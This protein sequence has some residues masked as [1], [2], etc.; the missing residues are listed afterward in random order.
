V[1]WVDSIHECDFPKQ[2]DFVVRR[3]VDVVIVK[4]T[5]ALYQ[6]NGK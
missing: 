1:L 2:I 3:C 6:L 5:V 4:N